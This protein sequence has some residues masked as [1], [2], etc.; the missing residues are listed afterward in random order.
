MT[1]RKGVYIHKSCLAAMLVWEGDPGGTRDIQ[2]QATICSKCLPH[3]IEAQRERTR[4]VSLLVDDGY[5]ESVG[6][7]RE[8]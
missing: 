3:N 5:A 7:G 6:L 2:I 1:S 4:L 8:V